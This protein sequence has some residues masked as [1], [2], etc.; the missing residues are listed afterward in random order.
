MFIELLPFWTKYW[1]HILISIILYIFLTLSYEVLKKGTIFIQNKRHNFNILDNT[2]EQLEDINQETLENSDEPV[3]TTNLKHI[4]YVY[5]RP[6]EEEILCR[7]SEF[8]KIVAARR[9]IRF[10][11]PDP[12]PKEVIH[13]IIKAAGTTPS[14]AHTEPWTFVAVSNQKVK[15][16]IR[17]IVESEEEINYKKRMGVKWTTD[18]LPLRTNWIKEYL[19]T[20]P[21]LIFV[22]KQIYGIL[23]NGNKKI[24][25]YNEMSTSIA[26][27]ILITAI[28]YAGLVTLTS[29]PLNCGPAIRNLLGRPPNERLVVLLPV[30]YPAKDATV[31][32]LQRKPLSDILIEID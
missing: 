14:G 10:F 21:Y 7:A 2:M 3:L 31:P 23:P 9:S 8:Y 17:L 13:E 26:C 16:Q 30:G 22:F 19:T 28:Q 4:P 25:Y 27:G 24:H 20:A 11:S 6:S 32:D 12:V 18:L 29:T 1:Y 5:K 15:E